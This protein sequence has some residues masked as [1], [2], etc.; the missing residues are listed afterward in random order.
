MMHPCQACGACCAA[1]RVPIYWSEAEQRGIDATLTEKID[2]LRL[3]MRVDNATH[4]RCIALEGEIGVATACRIYAQRP[5]PC[6]DLGAAWENGQ[7]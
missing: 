1:F 2:P 4:L 5:S 3:A 6:R 7:P